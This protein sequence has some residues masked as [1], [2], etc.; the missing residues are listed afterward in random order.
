MQTRQPRIVLIT[1]LLAFA[2]VASH[3]RHHRFRGRTRRMDAASA[4]ARKYRRPIDDK[5]DPDATYEK[6]RVN[7]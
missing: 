1:L 6:D 2:A 4:A 3:G 7:P 5:T